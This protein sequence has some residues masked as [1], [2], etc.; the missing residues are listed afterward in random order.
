MAKRP[1]GVTIIGVLGYIGAAFLLLS[2]I[3]MLVGSS[4]L[5]SVIA[6]IP[7]AALFGALGAAALIV[8][9]IVMI[10]FAVL[11]FFVSR[12]LMSG[13]N[14]ARITVLVLSAIGI[15]GSI[16]NPLAGIVTIAVNA[17]IIWYLGFNKEAKNYFR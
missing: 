17:V 6:S 16:S 2:G 4:A 7:G 3:A 9:G 5:A 13:R 1:I 11:Y 8:G 10:I 14:W 15:L 12:A